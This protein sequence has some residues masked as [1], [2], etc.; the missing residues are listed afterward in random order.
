MIR[1]DR[2]S[3][4]R[5]LIAALARQVISGHLAVIPTET[6]YALTADATSAKAIRTARAVKGRRAQQPFSVFF[7]DA[8]ALVRWR[9]TIPEWAQ[10][11]A[12]TFWPGP[13]TLIL[14]SRNPLFRRLGTTGSVG[15][16]VSPEPI[17]RMLTER[18]NRPLLATSANPSGLVLSVRDENIWLA[19]EAKN[20]KFL[21]VRPG[22]YQRCL[23]S[24][25]LDCCG[26]KPK[27]IRAGAIEAEAWRR[28][29]RQSR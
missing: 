9:I 14:P 23:P 7:A 4:S 2:R 15:V 24:T 10:P 25:V 12:G 6:Q 18:L 8:A 1:Y 29:L 27:L 21:W 3:P 13:L 17:V 11:L 5:P 20:S 22:R 28:A 19:Q 16:R 26:T